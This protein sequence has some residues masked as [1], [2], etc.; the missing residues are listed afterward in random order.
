MG[1]VSFGVFAL[2]VIYLSWSV[3]R[4][5]RVALVDDQLMVSSLTTQVEIPLEQVESLEWTQKAEDFNT[6]EAVYSAPRAQRP[7]Y[8]DPLRAPFLRS[9]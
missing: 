3:I 8:G 7:R 5:K 4:L 1:G 2:A 6:P 9:L